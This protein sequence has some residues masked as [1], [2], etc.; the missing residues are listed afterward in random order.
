MAPSPATIR[1]AAQSAA[2]A[3]VH[4]LPA[5]LPPPPYDLRK[6]F[7]SVGTSTFGA[8][9]GA[10]PAERTQSA[11]QVDLWD[12]ERTRLTGPPLTVAAFIDGIQSSVLVTHREHRPVYLA[13]QAAGAVGAGA[14]LI[15][16]S[17]RLTLMCSVVDEGWVGEINLTDTPIPV[18]TLEVTSP[19]DIERSAYTHLGDWRNRL[20]VRLVE[21]LTEAGVGPLIVDGSL[22]G[23]PHNLA[24][25][26]VVKDVLHT[27]Y[28]PDDSV[29]YGLPEGWRSPIFTLAP[30]GSGKYARP[31][32]IYSCYVRLH[33]AR[34][35]SWA[36]GL[37]RLE[38]FDPLALNALG[39]RAMVERQSP[40]SGDGRWDRHLVSVAMTEKV[41]RA[42]RPAVFDF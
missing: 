6:F 20:E 25:H 40:R 35:F 41:L 32:T 38:A 5:P 19:P 42:R 16:L 4:G 37:I 3:A 28:L 15:G 22:M 12:T 23:R 10:E 9:L 27:R 17:E 14:A 26:A 39:V 18:D 24:L 2:T 1:G 21:D 36:H 8:A 11:A 13:Y 30:G 31:H 34:Q 7:R 33:D 29:L